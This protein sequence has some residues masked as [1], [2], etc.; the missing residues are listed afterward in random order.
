MWFVKVS[1]IVFFIGFV[2]GWSGLI[3]FG[4]DRNFNCN[5]SFMADLRS[6][7]TNPMFIRSTCRQDVGIK[8]EC[9]HTPCL[10][11]TDRVA[12]TRTAPA[13]LSL[14]PSTAQSVHGV[15]YIEHGYG[16]FSATL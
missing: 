13:A 14:P 10:Y 15:T 1:E 3:S 4:A 12:L 2:V 6:R 5:W 7:I 16:D 9:H 8:V 11:V